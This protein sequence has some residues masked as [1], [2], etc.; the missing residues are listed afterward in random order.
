MTSAWS[1]C[2]L[3]CRLKRRPNVFYSRL[4]G[5]KVS[6]PLWNLRNLICI[7]LLL[8]RQCMFPPLQGG[9]LMKGKKLR[10]IIPWIFCLCLPWNLLL[11]IIFTASYS[12]LHRLGIF[13]FLY[14][15]WKKWELT[16]LY[17]ELFNSRGKNT[18]RAVEVFSLEIF[19]K[20]IQTLNCL[21]LFV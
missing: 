20:G 1:A 4:A 15:R 12:I 9:N 2:V 17:S 3:W 18:K 13:Y 21:K 19:R 11:N 16:F 8:F 7:F 14:V 6:I 5:V 10:S